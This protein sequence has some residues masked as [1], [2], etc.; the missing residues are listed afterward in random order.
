[1]RPCLYDEIIKMLQG[2]RT[3]QRPG[4]GGRVG[5][6]KALDTGPPDGLAQTVQ[7]LDGS[8]DFLSAR[9]QQTALWC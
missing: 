2:L 8:S 3:V 9:M 7:S 5:L 4:D 6:A 1:M